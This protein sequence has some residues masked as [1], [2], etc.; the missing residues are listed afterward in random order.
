MLVSRVEPRSRSPTEQRLYLF[1]WLVKIVKNNT[2]SPEGD[3]LFAYIG[4][5]VARHFACNR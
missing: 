3:V 2:V 1:Q 4:E 5:A